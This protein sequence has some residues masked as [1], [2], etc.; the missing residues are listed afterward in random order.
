MPSRWKYGA[1]SA[2]AVKPSSALSWSRYVTSGTVMRSCAQAADE[3]SSLLAPERR[4]RAQLELQQQQRPRRDLI[5][6][7]GP[8][9]V[10]GRLGRLRELRIEHERPPRERFVVAG[11][12]QRERHDVVMGVQNRQQRRVLTALL[13]AC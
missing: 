1:N 6:V 2:A 13:D 8:M 12:R 9:V 3:R 10:F 7:A 4:F 5:D 11:R